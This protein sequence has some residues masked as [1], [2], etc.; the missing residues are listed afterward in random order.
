MSNRPVTLALGGGGARG[1]A[2]LG[3][4][5]EVLRAGWSVERVIGISIGSMAGAMFAFDPDIDI[6]QRRTLDFLLAPQFVQRQRD[7]FRAQPGKDDVT[8]GG[9]FS[10]YHNV[11]DYLQAHQMLSRA[12]TRRSLLPGAVLEEVIH[13][14]LPDADIADAQIP[15]GIAALDLLTGERVVLERGP[16]RSA[17]QASA[18]LP[19]IFPPVEFDG[20]LLC[21][22]GVLASLPVRIARKYRPRTLLAVDVGS[23]LK[24]LRQYATALD[25]LMR[26]IDIGEA[27]FRA[28]L[29][30]E[31]DLVIAP[32]VG[33][34]EWWDFSDSK[35]LIDV[36]R[37]AAREVL[38]AYRPAR[39][40]LKR[41]WSH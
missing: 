33:N 26:I 39:S 28:D 9:L 20:R 34:I 3:V 41:F 18:S 16:L 37:E 15:L 2:H 17:V 4:I 1:V 31:A 30:A 40:L 7:L 36:G 8:R 11:A 12:V 14:L 24:P 21:D 6:V 35:R 23:N 27:T 32:S 38:S 5:E 13:H 29:R 25:V 22:L 19:G 10:W